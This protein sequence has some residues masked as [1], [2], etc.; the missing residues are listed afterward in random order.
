[1]LRVAAG[2][3]PETLRIAR[4]GAIVAFGK[5]DVVGDGYPE[6]VAAARA[7]GFE[8]IE[9][10]AGGRAAVFHDQTIS[11]AH[12]IPDDD[13]RSR[14]DERFDPAVGPDGPGLHARWASTPVWGRY[15]ASTAPAPTA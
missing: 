7:G 10:L 14:V 8:A 3:L 5:R 11:F 4:P 2:D 15:R 6:A 9:R 13:P 12:S 1:M